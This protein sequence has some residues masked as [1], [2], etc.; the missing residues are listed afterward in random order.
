MTGD[1]S[2][3]EDEDEPRDILGDHAYPLSNKDTKADI[4]EV[5]HS[6]VSDYYSR[7]VV[8]IMMRDTLD[9]PY[10]R[11]TSKHSD[12]FLVDQSALHLNVRVSQNKK[13][14]CQLMS[15]NRQLYSESELERDRFVDVGLLVE[16]LSRDRHRV[17]EGLALDQSQLEKTDL[18]HLLIEKYDNNIIYR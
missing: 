15:H 3:R 2:E 14:H 4:L 5:V 13:L 6:F 18:S 17:C 12:K 8:V 1:K 7:D 9:R 16:E 10:I 11:V